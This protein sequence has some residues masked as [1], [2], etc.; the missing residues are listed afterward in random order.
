MGLKM[1][2]FFSRFPFLKKIF[3]SFGIDVSGEVS[4]ETMFAVS[5][6]H[7]V[8]FGLVWTVIIATATRVTSGEVERGTA[9]ILLSLP[10]NRLETCISS[11]LVWIIAALLLSY[12]PLIGFWIS[13][14]VY[15]EASEIAVGNYVQPATNF[16]FLNLAVGGIASMCG[17]FLNRRGPAIGLVVTIVFVSVIL[18]FLE[19]FIEPLKSL[20]FL[21]AQ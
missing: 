11:S 17:S 19:Q 4:V 21:V 14:I 9:D 20:G 10:I 5:F 2:E 6:T 16:F 1:L 15:E 12:C 7:G 13:S 8:T 18:D 3:A